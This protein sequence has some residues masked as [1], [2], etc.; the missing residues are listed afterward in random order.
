MNDVNYE[1]LVNNQNRVTN[2]QIKIVNLSTANKQFNK[3][4]VKELFENYRFIVF[5]AKRG[6]LNLYGDTVQSKI[7]RIIYD[8]W[9]FSKEK[10]K[11]PYHFTIW[12]QIKFLVECESFSMLDYNNQGNTSDSVNYKLMIEI[13][14]DNIIHIIDTLIDFYV[15]NFLNLEWHLASNSYYLHFSRNLYIQ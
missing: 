7:R 12:S 8:N 3:S 15:S 9:K 10:L 4:Q 6:D 13:F 1:R 5:P 2:K 14:R 11:N